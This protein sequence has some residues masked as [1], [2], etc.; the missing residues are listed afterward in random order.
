M[1]KKNSNEYNKKNNIGEK[2]IQ[3][4]FHD[5]LIFLKIN[6]EIKKIRIIFNTKFFN[7]YM[8]LG[9]PL[10]MSGLKEVKL[11]ASPTELVHMIFC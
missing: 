1:K 11:N 5:I 4:E 6:Y 8:K 3:I 7:S 2:F 9:L 10:D